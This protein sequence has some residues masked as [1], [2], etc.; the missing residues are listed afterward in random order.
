MM[1]DEHLVA[2]EFTQTRT[3][4]AVVKLRAGARA[5]AEVRAYQAIQKLV[6]EGTL[7]L[8]VDMGEIFEDCDSA[9]EYSY[10]GLADVDDELSAYTVSLDI[11]DDQTDAERE[12]EAQQQQIPGA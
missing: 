2:I 12:T 3:S 8:E 11:T 6:A 4:F 7:E 5:E 10:E 9:V 1:A